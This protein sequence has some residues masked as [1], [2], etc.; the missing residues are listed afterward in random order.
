VCSSDLPILW[1]ESWE[2]DASQ[3]FSYLRDSDFVN[4]VVIAALD[5]NENPTFM[6]PHIKNKVD[7]A[8]E[9]NLIPVLA[10]DLWFRAGNCSTLPDAQQF[11]AN[12]TDNSIIYSADYYEWFMRELREEADSYGIEYVA[13]DTEVYNNNLPCYNLTDLWKAVTQLNNQPEN[14]SK[15][16]S[17]INEALNRIEADGIKRPDYIYPAEFYNGYSALEELGENKINEYTYWDCPPPSWTLNESLNH[18]L[19]MIGVW[20]T[21]TPGCYMPT[22]QNYWCDNYPGKNCFVFAAI[23]GMH[24]LFQDIEIQYWYNAHRGLFIYTVQG[25]GVAQQINNYCQANQ[26]IC[27]QYTYWNS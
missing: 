3:E 23:W 9:N 14:Y 10:R 19:D 13:I 12:Y 17:A 15:V 6:Y 22:G 5:Y 11:I 24:T 20:M 7:L 25:S 4:Y 18:D 26:T 1:Y 16:Q 2:Q 21:T 27:E 8:R